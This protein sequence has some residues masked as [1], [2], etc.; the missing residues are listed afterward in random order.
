MERGGAKESTTSGPNWCPGAQ[1]RWFNWYRM[2]ANW[3]NARARRCGAAPRDHA[4]QSSP[5]RYSRV[6]TGID[7]RSRGWRWSALSAFAD[8]SRRPRPVTG[9]LKTHAAGC[10]IFR[11]GWWPLRKK[12]DVT[13]HVNC[14]M[15]S[16]PVHVCDVG[17]IGPSG[18]NWTKRQGLSSAAYLRAENGGIQRWVGIR[19][20]AL[21]LRPS[22]LDDLG[23]IPRRCAGRLVRLHAALAG[24][25]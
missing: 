19:N 2:L 7:R 24:R 9:M 25:K 20:I 11:R 8:C 5:P 22:M 4:G 23:L 10:G 21:L 18:S 13:F 6:I 14:T 1:H 16:R 15:K 17:G 3:M 12:N